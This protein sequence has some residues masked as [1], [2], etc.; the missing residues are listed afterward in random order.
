MWDTIIHKKSFKNTLLTSVDGHPEAGWSR[1]SKHSV[2]GQT[3]PAGGDM[4]IRLMS[5]KMEKNIK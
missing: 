1:V 2:G 4:S 3:T 5:A